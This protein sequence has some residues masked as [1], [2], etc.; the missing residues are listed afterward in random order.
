MRLN[1]AI[2]ADLLQDFD[3]ADLGHHDVQQGD[4]R[5]LSAEH[6]HRLRRVGGG[7]EMRVSVTLQVLLDDL[8]VDRFV[9]HDHDLG[10]LG[11]V[12]IHRRPASSAGRFGHQMQRGLESIRGGRTVQYSRG[13]EIVASCE[14]PPWYACA[15]HG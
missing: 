15:R 7:D 1:L 6:L 13:G 12:S 2:G 10:A 14:M 3:A 9:V 11:R 5:P 8:N 4:V